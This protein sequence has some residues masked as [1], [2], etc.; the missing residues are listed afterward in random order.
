MAAPW[1]RG[2]EGRI[3]GK[4]HGQDCINVFHFAT[5]NVV[6]DGGPLD[7]LLL[8]LAVAMVDCAFQTLLPAVTQ[9]YRLVQC[10]ARAI[11]PTKTDPV[12]QTAPANATG[13][14][15]S[16]SVS[17]AASLVNIRTGGGGRRGRGR[18]FFPPP[19]EE[20]ITNGLIDNPTLAALTAFLNCMAGKFTGLNPSTMW[21]LG[22]YS[23][24]NDLAVG[25]DFNNSFREATQLSP[26]AT[27]AVLSSRKIGHGN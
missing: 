19:G 24:T 7:D 10:D 14:L 3:V 9:D 1:A 27:L 18:K 15:T 11:F 25:G 13:T 5:N 2:A 12:I 8:Q 16:T 26:S 17:F 21:R 6:N 22:V 20:N 4:L 23:R